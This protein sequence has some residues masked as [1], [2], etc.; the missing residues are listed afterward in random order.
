MFLEP[1]F[2]LTN[3]KEIMNEADLGYGTFYQY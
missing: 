3:V 1:G 2:H